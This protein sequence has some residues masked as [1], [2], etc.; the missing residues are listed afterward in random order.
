[1]TVDYVKVDT[2][3]TATVNVTLEMGA[4]SAEVTVAGLLSVE[5]LCRVRANR[6]EGQKKSDIE[7]GIA[8]FAA[9]AAHGKI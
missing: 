3:V 7:S 5:F 2:G 6:L 9:H 8:L 1:V 4:A